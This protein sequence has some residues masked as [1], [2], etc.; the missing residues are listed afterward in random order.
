MGTNEI[1]NDAIGPGVASLDHEM[2]ALQVESV[3][4]S[5]RSLK[6]EP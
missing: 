3:R 6:L 4:V 1:S 2:K 5:L